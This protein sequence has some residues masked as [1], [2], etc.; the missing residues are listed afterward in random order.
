LAT[1]LPFPEQELSGAASLQ[2][3]F[4]RD[5]HPRSRRGRS[6]SRIEA[7]KDARIIIPREDVTLEVL[8]FTL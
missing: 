4:A 6:V 2:R 5:D 3:H 1:E 8:E 7:S